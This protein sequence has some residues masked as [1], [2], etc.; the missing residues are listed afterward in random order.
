M[1]DNK[2]CNNCDIT[3]PL[4]EFPKNGRIYRAICKICHCEKQ[5]K[6]YLENHEENLV[7]KK[8]NYQKNKDIILQNNKVYREANKDSVNEQKKEYYQKNRDEI[9]QKLKTKNYKDKRNKYLQDRRKTD[10]KFSMVCSYRARLNDVLHKQKQNTYIYY[11][12]CKRNMFLDWIEFQFD[13]VFKWEDYGKKW[14]IDH[15]I[16]IDFF[17]LDIHIHREKC[18]SWFNLRPCCILENMKK[19]NKILEDI[20]QDHQNLINK[21]LEINGYQTNVEIHQWL[22]QELRY[23]KNPYVLDNSQPSL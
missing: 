20:V 11:L 8:E 2:K 19:S 21:Y 9:L 23:G 13:N 15:V 3:K 6:R 1:M 22:R 17:N 14:V 4:Q 16:P 18:F 10:K 5:K 7:K 12:N